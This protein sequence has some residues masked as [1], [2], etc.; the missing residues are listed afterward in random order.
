M[1]THDGLAPILSAATLGLAVV[2]VC[3]AEPAGAL[4][5][6]LGVA[7]LVDLSL[8]GAHPGVV[9][10]LA[11]AALAVVMIGLGRPAP[12]WQAATAVAG[13]VIASAH[14]AVFAAHGSQGFVHHGHQLLS[15]SVCM[16]ALLA[17]ARVVWPAAVT[18]AL[19][20]RTLVAVVVAS[21]ATA[22]LHKLIASDGRWLADVAL[23]V[24]D[25]AKA[26]LEHA[27]DHSGGAALTAV[28]GTDDPVQEALRAWPRLA[29]GA[30][31][32]ALVVELAAP[33]ALVGRG[34]AFVIGVALIV[35]HRGIAAVMGITFF[36]HEAL[37]A[38]WLVV[39]VVVDVVRARAAAS[40][41]PQVPSDSATP[42]PD[43]P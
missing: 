27:I 41:A 18:A 26:R 33:L 25:V 40:R 22:G 31:G 4:V 8:V 13:A 32:L 2:D 15:Q 9:G 14:V 19:V 11:G 42:S 16:L 28:V 3:A 39:P 17:A 7:R 29:A 34:P 23:L 5:T 10:A 24:V 6:P 30:F 1:S 37:V 35:M 36:F 12:R 21:Y 43:A 20:Q 38:L